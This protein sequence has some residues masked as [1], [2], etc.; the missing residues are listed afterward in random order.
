MLL[1]FAIDLNSV[2]DR[3]SIIYMMILKQC[4]LDLISSVTYKHISFN[5]LLSSKMT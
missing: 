1:F 2:I 4:F 5:T 3:S